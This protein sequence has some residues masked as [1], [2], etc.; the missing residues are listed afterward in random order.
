MTIEVQPLL[1][2]LHARQTRSTAPLTW[3][4]A[5][6]HISV[7]G[8]GLHRAKPRT[9]DLLQSL[10]PRAVIIT[11]FAGALTDALNPGDIITPA[12]LIDAGSHTALTPATLWNITPDDLAMVSVEQIAATPQLKT[13]LAAAHRAQA[14]D[15]ESAFIAQACDAHRVPWLCI[16]AISDSLGD[17]IPMELMELVKD[18]GEADVLAGAAWALRRP[19]LIGS[20]RQL[21]RHSRSAAHAL[22]DRLWRLLIANR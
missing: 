6:A 16:R 19:S 3:Q 15:M 5:A 11:G 21:Q 9:T 7:T 4:S 12:R 17:T 18:N 10:K 1:R 22:A 20:M 2:K 14:A 13:S 8:V